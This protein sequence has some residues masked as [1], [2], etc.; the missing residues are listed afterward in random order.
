MKKKDSLPSVGTPPLLP[1]ALAAQATD[2]VREILAEAASANTTRS[3]AT[4][5]RYWAAWHQARYGQPIALP[6]SD[7]AVVQFIVDHLA[8][9]AKTGLVWE[10]PADLDA[11]LVAADVKQQLGPLKL[12][13]VVH[14]VAVLSTAHQLKQQPNLVANLVTWGVTAISVEPREAEW[15]YQILRQGQV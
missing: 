12:S 7:A 15:V 2:A 3:Y 10:L 9:R 4:A 14:R 13:T 1:Q 5:L 8:R 11:Q 6:V